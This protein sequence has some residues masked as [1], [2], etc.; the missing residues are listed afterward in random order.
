MIRRLTLETTEA[1]RGMRLDTLLA[2]SLPP[3]LGRPLSKAKLRRLIMAG[4]VRIGGRAFRRPGYPLR[5]GA[6]VEAAVQLDRL[7]DETRRDVAFTLAATEILYEDEALIAVNKPPGLPTPPTVDPARPHLLGI[8]QRYL[9]QRGR[10]RAY[11]GLHQRLD[12]DTSGVVLFTK[13]RAANAGLADLF[14]RR[15]VVKTYHALTRRPVLL[16]PRSWRAVSR[17]GVRGRGGGKRMASLGSGGALAET[18]FTLLEAFLRG[19][20]VEAHPRTGRKHQVRVHLAEAGLPILGDELYGGGAGVPRPML[21][22]R[23]LAFHHPR[24]GAEIVIRSPYPDDFRRALR[25]L[26][27]HRG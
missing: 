9:E 22:A 23:S 12:R 14:A 5:P 11:V 19:V 17:L 25:A 18:D 13:E 3:A 26:R 6:R 2:E 7:E 8:V 10:R 21:H 16:P 27:G 15:E 4:A 1:Q 20:L 24:T